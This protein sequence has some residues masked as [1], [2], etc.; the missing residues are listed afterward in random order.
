MRSRFLALVSTVALILPFMS[1]VAL[2]NKNLCGGKSNAVQCQ[3]GK[4]GGGN[5]FYNFEMDPRYNWQVDPRYNWQADPKYNWK[6]DP[7][8]NWKANPKLNPGAK[9]CD[10]GISPPGKS[11]PKKKW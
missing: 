11:C 8:Y 6:A 3:G 2:A 5:G 7:K 1:P 4:I 9:P 10:L